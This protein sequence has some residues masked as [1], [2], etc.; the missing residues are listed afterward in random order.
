M[1]TFLYLLSK[2][3]DSTII[4]KVEEEVKYWIN[5]ILPGLQIVTPFSPQL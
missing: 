4:L 2:V 1:V 5:R 3:E